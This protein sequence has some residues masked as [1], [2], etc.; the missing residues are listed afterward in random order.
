MAFH[1]FGSLQSGLCF[2]QDL[3]SLF[4]G[5]FHLKINSYSR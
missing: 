5:N 2:E 4:D 1:V 3:F